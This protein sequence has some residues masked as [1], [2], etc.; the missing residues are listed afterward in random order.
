MVPKTL[1]DAL[2]SR[3]CWWVAVSWESWPISWELKFD[4]L[5]LLTRSNISNPWMRYKNWWWHWRVADRRRSRSM[6]TDQRRYEQRTR[7]K[8][9]QTLNIQEF[10][11]D[12]W[13]LESAWRSQSTGV[14]VDCHLWYKR[15]CINEKTMRWNVGLMLITWV[16]CG[17]EYRLLVVYSSLTLAWHI[18]TPK[19]KLLWVW[20]QQ[21]LDT[22]DSFHSRQGRTHRKPCSYGYNMLWPMEE[23]ALTRKKVHDRDVDWDL[24]QACSRINYDE[25]VERHDFWVHEWTRQSLIR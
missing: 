5:S 20:A 8:S 4:V 3:E 2:N 13:S 6:Y 16:A 1:T 24:D 18:V 10:V 14:S 9:V 11:R 21:M 17:H 19:R 15:S 12:L 7:R 25:K 23:F 22:T